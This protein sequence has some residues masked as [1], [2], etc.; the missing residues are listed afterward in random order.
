[1]LTRPA[2]FRFR[3]I[4]SLVLRV[5]CRIIEYSEKK[6]TNKRTYSFFWTDTNKTFTHVMD[7]AS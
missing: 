4:W 1:M 5:V 3:F 6:S 7:K 2:L